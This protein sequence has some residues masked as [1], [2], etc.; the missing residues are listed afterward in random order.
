LYLIIFCLNVDVFKDRNTL[1]RAYKI[2]IV[3]AW[4]MSV[5]NTEEMEEQHQDVSGKDRLIGLEVNETDSDFDTV[6]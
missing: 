5:W 3:N 4:R 6:M 2:R 1:S